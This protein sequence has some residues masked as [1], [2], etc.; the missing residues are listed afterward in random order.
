MGWLAGRV[1]PEREG[2]ILVSTTK[3]PSKCGN[4]FFLRGKGDVFRRWRWFWAAARVSQPFILD[5]LR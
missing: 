5:A 3:P 4:R 2:I 1:L